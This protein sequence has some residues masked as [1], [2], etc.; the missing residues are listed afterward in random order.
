MRLF[1]LLVTLTSAQI[2]DLISRAAD[3][4]NN[5]ESINEAFFD[6]DFGVGIARAQASD[7]NRLQSLQRIVQIETQLKTLMPGHAADF[8][9]PHTLGELSAR[10]DF[11]ANKL[12]ESAEQAVAGSRPIADDSMVSAWAPHARK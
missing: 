10:V 12:Y 11:L 5:P 6:N 9:I 3:L 2:V 1:L 8:H 7:F 4:E